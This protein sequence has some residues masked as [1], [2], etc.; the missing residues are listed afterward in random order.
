MGNRAYQ[1]R[2]FRTVSIRA[3]LYERI[4]ELY[5][6]LDHSSIAGYVT[7]AIMDKLATDEYKHLEILELRIK[8]KQRRVD[9]SDATERAV[10]DN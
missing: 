8:D 5:W 3:T 4:R 9:L 7:K 10:D 6:D 1:K 2:N